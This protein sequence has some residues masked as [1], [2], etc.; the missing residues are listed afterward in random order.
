MKK[1]LILGT[2]LVATIAFTGCSSVKI[3]SEDTSTLMRYDGTNTDYSKLDSYKK[4]TV[5][6]SYE[7]GRGYVGSTSV[8][9]AA[10]QAGISKVKH[11]DVHTEYKETPGFMSSTKSDFKKCVTVYGE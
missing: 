8:A 6:T 11:V 1:S 10:K 9:D 3:K 4:G 2:I 5:C 7:V